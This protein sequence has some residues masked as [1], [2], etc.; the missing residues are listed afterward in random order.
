[1][2]LSAQALQGQGIASVIKKATTATTN[3]PNTPGGTPPSQINAGGGNTPSVTDYNPNDPIPGSSVY[4]GE[5]NAANLAYENAKNQLLSQRNSLYHQYG[6]LDNG[7]VDPNNQFGAYQLL[8]GNEGSAL[9]A[10][11]NDALDRGLGTGG[12]AMQGESALRNAQ[13]A[14]QLAFQQQ[15]DRVGSDYA[16]GLAGAEQ[17]RS[18]AT[19][20]AY[21][22]ALN[23]AIASG[24]FTP[25]ATP[26]Y[27]GGGTT[28]GVN[29]TPTAKAKAKVVSTTAKAKT[30]AKVVS[31]TAARVAAATKG[32]APTAP[33]AVRV[34]ANKSGASANKKQGI[35]S[36]H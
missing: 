23:T 30:K 22:D 12:L 19:N 2:P 6:L 1:M 7:A 25:A 10:A 15:V 18:S 28:T 17:T 26:T 32:K 36:I 31:T 14:E 34:T 27:T 11:D 9:D 16:S 5:Q 20:Q 33:V 21:L 13:G 29:D 8:L 3:Q 24:Y 35:F 4:L